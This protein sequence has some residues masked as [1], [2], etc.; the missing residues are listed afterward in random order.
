MRAKLGVIAPAREWRERYAHHNLRLIED[1]EGSLWLNVADLRQWLPELANDEALLRRHPGLLRC[2]PPSKA[3]MIEVGAF[4]VLTGDAK[5]VPTLKL[6]AWVERTLIEPARRQQGGRTYAGG[7]GPRIPS[8][9]ISAAE[10]PISLAASA[11]GNQG[12]TTGP[13][14]DPRFWRI[15]TGQWGLL[16]TAGIGSVGAFGA[17]AVSIV[18]NEQ[19]WDVDNNY[20]LWTWVAIGLAIWAV[21]FNLAWAVGAVRS[22][23]RRAG[24]LFNPWMTI[25]L[26]TMNLAAAAYTY[27]LTL[28]NTSYLVN[29]W[30]T[31]YVVGAPAADVIVSDRHANGSVKQLSLIGD[32]G[33]GSTQELRRA[34]RDHP[35]TTT[36]VLESPGGLVIEGFGLAETI[37]SSQIKTTIVVEDCSSACTLAYLQGEHRLIGPNGTLGFHRSYSIFG[38]FRDGWSPV[39]HMAADFMRKRGVA[40]AFIQRALDTPGWDIYET[41]EEEALE[42]GVATG[43][44]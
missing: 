7:F 11:R 32:L 14:W 8:N 12:S 10:D 9:L 42:N 33:I 3:A 19:A 2:A 40:E 22:G 20:L 16:K 17:V 4:W 29:L 27:G 5:D 31:A 44:L 21:L 15:A 35:S 43:R 24:D 18:L 36:L 41:R 30:W 6:R 34:L 23:L 28:N 26:V 13:A 39:D 25:V 1:E 38:E 37:A